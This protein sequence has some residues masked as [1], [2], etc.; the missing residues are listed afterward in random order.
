MRALG[1]GAAVKTVFVVRDGY[2][3]SRPVGDAL[4]QCFKARGWRVKRASQQLSEEPDLIAGWGFRDIMHTA[5]DRWPSKVLH[6]DAGFWRRDRYYKLALGGRWS[7]VDG[8]TDDPSRFKAHQIQVCET[9][10]PGQRVLIAGMSGK[11]SIS[12]GMQPLA[13]EKEAIRRLKAVG[14]DVL[15]RPKPSAP[16]KGPIKGADYNQSASIEHALRLVSAVASH[17]SNACI[18]ALAFGLPIYVEVGIAKPMSVLRL[19]DVVGADARP[20]AERKRF[21]HSVAH[22]QWTIEELAAGTWLRYPEPITRM[23]SF[24]SIFGG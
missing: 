15:Y 22:H 17:H 14:A 16:D 24:S 6:V 4:E 5:W 19:E 7:S 9:R 10:A 23:P 3:M 1:A 8:C 11:A 20:H 21:L 12:W 2:S 13:W 18:D